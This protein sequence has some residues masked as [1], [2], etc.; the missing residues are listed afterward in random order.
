VKQAVLGAGFLLAPIAWF[1]S[2]EANF[3]LAPL[4]C[5]GHQK[6]VLLLISVTALGLAAGG[7][8]LAWTQR[9]SRRRLAFF[10]VASSALFAL[11]IAA[12]TIP[13]LMLRGCE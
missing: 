9:T 4:A 7:S 8:F 11:V 10:G 6:S 13:N 12:Q 1:A 2:M 3:A 5:G